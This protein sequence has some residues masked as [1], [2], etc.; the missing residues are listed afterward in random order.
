MNKRQKQR[1]LT[2]TL[3]FTLFIVAPPLDIFRFDL[4]LNH[5]ILFGQPWTL[6]LEAFQ[7]GDVTPMQAGLNIILRGFV[8]LALVAGVGFW[9][10]WR[11]GRLYCGWLCPHFSVVEVISNCHTSYGRMNKFASPVAMLE[12][13]RDNSVSVK[14][15][16]HMDADALEGKFTR[17][18]MVESDKPEFIQS[19]DEMAERMTADPAAVANVKKIVQAYDE[20]VGRLRKKDS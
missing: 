10:S 20:S 16:E 1:L 6:G 13:M 12:W 2:R 7:S 11:W 3:F 18:V 15:A 4:T 5:F 9:V 17:G 19:Y 8:P 14:A